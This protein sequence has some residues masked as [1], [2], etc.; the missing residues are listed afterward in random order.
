MEKD[1]LVSQ[2]PEQKDP[3]RV[4]ASDYP[5]P[6]GSGPH[7]QAEGKDQLAGQSKNQV[8]PRYA[9]GEDGGADSMSKRAAAVSA[10]F[11]VGKANSAGSSLSI[12]ES[13]DLSTGKIEAKSV[14]KTKVGEVPESSVSI[15]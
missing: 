6:K 5:A 4:K 7:G 15:G 13:V 1:N 3:Y 12:A 11:K 14:K 8:G 9:E 10:N 2:T